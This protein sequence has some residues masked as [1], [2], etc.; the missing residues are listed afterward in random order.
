MEILGHT[1]S[2]VVYIPVS[3][4]QNAVFYIFHFSYGVS[5]ISRFMISFENYRNACSLSCSVS[6][7]VS[8]VLLMITGVKWLWELHCQ[9]VGGILGDEMG[10]GK[11][12]QVI[13]FLAALHHSQ[14]V[15]K[16]APRH[17]GLGKIQ[18]RR[19]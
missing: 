17:R 8:L 18:K 16:A 12:I 4:S 5:N 14:I 6:L 1:A 15:D 19:Q 11:T 3:G 10:L 9:Q 7:L 13:A 2:S